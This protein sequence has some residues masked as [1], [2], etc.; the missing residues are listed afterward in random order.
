M[1]PTRFSNK[2]K[3]MESQRDIQRTVKEKA[4]GKP[5]GNSKDSKMENQRKANGKLKGNHF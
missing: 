5:K 3:L 4:D 2:G 1:K